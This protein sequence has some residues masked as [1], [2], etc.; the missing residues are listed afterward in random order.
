MRST[1][2]LSFATFIIA[3]FHTAPAAAD[4]VDDVLA[5][6]SVSVGGAYPSAAIERQYIYTGQGLSGTVI[7]RFDTR[8][9]AYKIRSDL[10]AI[11]VGSGYDG[12]TP[13][14]RDI[15]GA[16]TRQEGGDRVRLAVN[17]AYRHANLWW[18]T[19]R[20]GAKI[21]YLGRETI[22]AETFERLAVTPRGGTRFEAWFNVR[23]GLLTQV[24]ERQL[25][26]D[27]RT[28]YQ[29]YKRRGGFLIPTKLI[30]DGGTGEASYATMALK[31]VSRKRAA[32]L[33]DYAAPSAAPTGVTI[34]GDV[35]SV[36]LPFRLLNNHI[37]IEASV[38]GRGPY[39]FIVDTGGHTILS[40]RI[41]M[42]AGLSPAGAAPSSGAGAATITSGYA[43]VREIAFGPIRMHDQTAITM[44]IYDP[45]VEGIRVDG[46]I[47]FELLRRLAVEIDYGR[48]R[49]TFTR[50]KDFD[51]AAAGVAVPFTFYDHLPQVRGRIDGIPALFDIDT[52]SRNEVD[53]TSPFV[54]ANKLETRFPGSIKAM[55]GWGVGG[56][57]MSQVVRV[58]TLALG[59]IV[60]HDPVIGLSRA[61]AGSFSDS[62]FGGNV[63]SGLLKRFVTSFDYSKQV[64]YLKSI[65]PTPLDAGTFDRS[66]MWLNAGTDHF[67]VAYISPGG[68][69]EAAG[70]K[71]DNVVTAI[72]GRPAVA[73]ELSDVR[74]IF[75]TKT[76]GAR[77]LITVVRDGRSEIIPLTLRDRL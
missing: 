34:D 21:A 68:A 45:A 59:P 75:R 19:D 70:I 4:V 20:G 8:T 16:Y 32:P 7:V 10:G 74:T 55:T 51:A 27:T 36:T 40:S 12:T 41:V 77:V 39:T 71:K 1:A 66:G 38:E 25:F 29:D 72:D 48:S 28:F 15:S 67:I 69:A 23:S 5:S 65:E 18:R 14:M 3:F 58:P 31:E 63:G 6:Y 30:V 47:G 22:G 61:T 17:E 52:G 26:F 60:I 53:I 35:R 44:D 49:L 73:A 50:F 2:L 33:S 43:K 62:N 13:W 64:M 9:G 42:E 46:M 76:H 37:Y 57:S 54:T 24:A 11:V 56:P